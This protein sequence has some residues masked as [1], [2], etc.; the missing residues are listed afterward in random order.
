M[1][2]RDDPSFKKYFGF[3]LMYHCKCR[4]HKTF[5]ITNN[6]ENN[7]LKICRSFHNVQWYLC[8]PIK[9]G[10]HDIAKITES[11]V[12]HQQT[13]NFCVVIDTFQSGMPYNTFNVS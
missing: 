2:W 1:K 4:L 12:K 8:S 3:S 9:T 5:Q 7:Q 13:G 10:R 6:T 11:S